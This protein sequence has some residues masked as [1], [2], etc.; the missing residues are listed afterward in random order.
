MGKR[1]VEESERERG[2]IMRKTRPAIA[3]FKDGRVNEQRNV[4]SV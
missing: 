4:G 3:D 2:G 1:E